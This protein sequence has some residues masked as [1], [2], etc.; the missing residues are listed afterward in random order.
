MH[1][2]AWRHR[3]RPAGYLLVGTAVLAGACGGKSA[4][5]DDG[6]DT[7]GKG[8]AT[9][10]AGGTSSGKGGAGDTT[11]MGG[12]SV[13]G[14]SGTGDPGK[15][16]SG[17]E[18]NC[19]GVLC[20]PIPTT[21]KEIVQEV[22]A[23]CPICTDTGCEKCP[24]LDCEEGTHAETVPGDCCPSCLTDP[25]DACE[26]GMQ[27][28]DQLREALLEKYGSLGCVNSTECT[29]VHEDN[30]CA[31]SCG[32][33]LPSVTAS[34]YVDN[35]SSAAVGCS[36]CEPPFPIPCPAGGPAACVNGKCMMAA[37]PR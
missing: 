13:G 14:S 24:D 22:G 3:I 17:A 21:C 19:G 18:P 5:D 29:V 15:G 1:V 8:G 36:T 4:T 9:S 33:V 10:A 11:S 27:A 26:M 20:S 2:S 35:L 28:Y 30:A 12:S 34:S 37:L 23:C 32:I 6:N 25:P 31:A 7:S 16:G